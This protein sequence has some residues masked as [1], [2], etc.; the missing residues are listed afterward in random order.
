M[1]YVR[2]RGSHLAI[3]HGSRHPDSK[4]VE[5]HV[6]VT[7]HSKAEAL[8][9][10]RRSKKGLGGDFHA[11]MEHRYPEVRFDWAAIDAAI[12]EHMDHLPDLA[13]SREARATGGFEDAHRAQ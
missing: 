2:R 9:A 3:V 13:K 5:Q 10:I 11:L 12:A 6:L 4:K 1:P 7:L 8:A